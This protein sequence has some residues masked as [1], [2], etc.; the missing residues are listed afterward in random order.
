MFPLGRKKPPLVGIDISSTSIK[1]IELGR[2]GNGYRV[3]NYAVEPLPAGAVVEKQI[4]DVS[5]VA[6]AI[7]NAIKKAD[8]KTS[9][10]ALAVPSSAAITKN[11]VMAANLSETEIEAQIELEADQ[12]IPFSVDEVNLDFELLGTNPGNAASVD[13]LL[14]ASRTENVDSR[15][16]TAEAAGLLPTIMDIESFATANAFELIAQDTGVSENQVVAVVDIGATMTS[17]VVIQNDQVLYTREQRFGGQQ[18]T[19]DIMRRYGLSYAEAGREKKE[20][21]LPDNYAAEVLNPFIDQLVQQVN[22]LLQ[23]FLASGGPD[24]IHQLVLAGGCASIPGIDDILEARLEIPASI[25]N[26]FR[27]MGISNKINQ[28]RLANDAP[29]MMIACGLALRGHD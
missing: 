14:A 15:S 6:N 5:A 23:F 27:T 8:I 13:I 20:G 25:A 19:E 17:V 16:A 3:E 29:A 28:Q 2:S 4:S 18:L 10:C 22:R 24:T 21:G 26:P 11:I 9:R 1:L 12:Y 7:S